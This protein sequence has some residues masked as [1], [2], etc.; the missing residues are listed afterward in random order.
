ME[1][2]RLIQV[3][4]ELK[5]GVLKGERAVTSRVLKKDFWKRWHLSWALS[6]GRS[7]YVGVVMA[8]K[9]DILSLWPGT[10]GLA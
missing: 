8:F 5:S 4:Q 6:M 2:L 1:K 9:V 3:V 10:R 7:E